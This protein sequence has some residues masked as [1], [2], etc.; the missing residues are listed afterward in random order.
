M[1]RRTSHADRERAKKVPLLVMDHGSSFMARRFQ[2]HIRGLFRHVRIAFRTPTQLGLPERFDQ[3]LRSEEVHWPC[4]TVRGM[5]E[6]VS[7]S[8]ASAITGYRP[9][10]Y[11]F[12]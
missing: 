11:W 7:T 5:R 9:T 12:W 3:T 6:P 1:S 4:M 8:F 2:E 10:G